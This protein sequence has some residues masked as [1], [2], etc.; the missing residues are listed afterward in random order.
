MAKNKL[1]LDVIK[2]LVDEL[3]QK[4]V[5]NAKVKQLCTHL[6]IP[7]NGDILELMTFLLGSEMLKGHLAQQKKD[8]NYTTTHVQNVDLV[9]KTRPDVLGA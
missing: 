7:F 1:N 4:N 8:K 6:K 5:S 9:K 2:E 3:S